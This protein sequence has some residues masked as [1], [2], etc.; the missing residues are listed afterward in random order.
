MLDTGVSGNLSPSLS[1]HIEDEAVPVDLQMNSTPSLRVR[2]EQVRGRHQDTMTTKLEERSFCNRRTWALISHV[3]VGGGGVVGS[4]ILNMII[5]ITDKYFLNALLAILSFTLVSINN[6]ECVMVNKLNMEIN[7]MDEED[8]KDFIKI[9]AGAKH[10]L[11]WAKGV[12][13]ERAFS[14]TQPI[15]A[16]KWRK[17][18]LQL[19]RVL[20]K[21]SPHLYRTM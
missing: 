20:L 18:R 4:F 9:P 17:R 1:E 6:L 8:M 15:F 16:L 7:S 13:L 19:Q 10:A 12:E 11:S 3:L 5:D 14:I 2:Q 21:L